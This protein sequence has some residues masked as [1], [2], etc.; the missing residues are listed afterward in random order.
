MNDKKY[1]ILMDKENTIEWEGRTLH[2]IRALKDFR[3]V[4]TP[5]AVKR[6]ISSFGKSLTH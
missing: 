4:R 5:D 3:N 1:E 2:R 6:R